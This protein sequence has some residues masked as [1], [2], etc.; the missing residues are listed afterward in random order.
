MVDFDDLQSLIRFS[1]YKLVRRELCCT[2][3]GGSVELIGG[4]LVCTEPSAEPCGKYV[5]K[6]GELAVR[7][8]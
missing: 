8:S 4:L 3:C 2:E 5:E 7:A 6:L 1:R